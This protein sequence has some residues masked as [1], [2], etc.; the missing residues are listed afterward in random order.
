MANKQWIAFL[1]LATVLAA[2]ESRPEGPKDTPAATTIY[3]SPTPPSLIPATAAVSPSTESFITATILPPHEKEVTLP[4][5]FA[6]PSLLKTF[7]LYPGASW[8]YRKVGYSQA[9]DDP[10]KII[11]GTAAITE[12]VAGTLSKPPYRIVH[13]LGDKT[14]LSSDPGW[15]ENGTFGLGNYEYWYVVLG[16]QV[17]LSYAQ[18]DPEAIQTR[19]MLLEFQFPLAMGAQWC[20]SSLEKGYLT[21]PAETPAPCEFAGMRVVDGEGSY[22]TPVGDFD[23]C[24][25]MNDQVNSGGVTRWF[26]EGVGIVAEKYDHAGSQFGFTQE[27]VRFTP[28]KPQ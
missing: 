27:L 23:N 7:P 26:C 6:G 5:T 2:C 28:G 19:R 11:R 12:T 22:Q 16:D 24:F 15:E 25:R 13:I 1:L 4:G 14:M 20:P 8:A 3:Y 21:P 17:Y 9:P 10:N 18:P